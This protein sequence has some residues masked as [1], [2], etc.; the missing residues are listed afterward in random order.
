MMEVTSRGSL[1]YLSVFIPV[2]HPIIALILSYDLAGIFHD[3]LMWFKSAVASY[4]IAT[5]SCFDNFDTNVVL[6]S[7]F[8]APF[9]VLKATIG[10]PLRTS[11]TVAVIAFEEHGTVETIIFTAVSRRA[12]AL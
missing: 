1:S 7:G 10:A 6:S 2:L 12:D 5:I 8:A 11:A 4:T 3:D 9:Q